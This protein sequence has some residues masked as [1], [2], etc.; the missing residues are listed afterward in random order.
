MHI[1]CFIEYLHN[2]ELIWQSKIFIGYIILLPLSHVNVATYGFWMR[3]CHV[4]MIY[5]DIVI[6]DSVYGEKQSGVPLSLLLAN[7]N[8]WWYVNIGIY[9]VWPFEY[10]NISE[11]M[12]IT[13]NECIILPIVLLL[14]IM[15]LCLVSVLRRQL[16]V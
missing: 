16:K 1:K 15:L 2:Y 6:N 14:I 5:M 11:E 10:Q 12:V 8:L 9:F 4:I 13:S 7:G 3:W